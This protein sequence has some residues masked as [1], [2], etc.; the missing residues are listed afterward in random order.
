MASK[1]L[2]PASNYNLPQSRHPGARRGP[3]SIRG[4]DFRR[5]DG[6]AVGFRR[7]DD[8]VGEVLKLNPP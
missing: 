6:F 2:Y 3:Q 5:G 7:G 4:P 1:M 8:Y